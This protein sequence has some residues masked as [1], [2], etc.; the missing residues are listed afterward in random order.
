MPEMVRMRHHLVVQFA[1]APPL[2]QNA[3]AW[4]N[5]R[6]ASQLGNSQN[7]LVMRSHDRP[8]YDGRLAG[9]G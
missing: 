7:I 3:H 1:H 4:H 5:R 9:N 6:A 8:E 2:K